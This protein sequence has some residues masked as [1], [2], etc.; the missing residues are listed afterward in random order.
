MTELLVEFILALVLAGI[1]GLV[2][3]LFETKKKPCMRSSILSTAFG[4]LG[5][6]I[7]T[8]WWT[9]NPIEGFIAGFAL[10]DILNSLYTLAIGGTK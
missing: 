4:L 9:A 5:F 2:R 8:I 10:S 1:G 7:L 6:S 3:S